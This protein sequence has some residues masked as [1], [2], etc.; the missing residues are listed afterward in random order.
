MR[1]NRERERV[2]GMSAEAARTEVFYLDPRNGWAAAPFDAEGNQIGEAITAFRQ[3]EAVSLI[4]ADRPDL[5]THVFNRDGTLR[6]IHP[7]RG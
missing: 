6:R 1:P 7:P 4:R 2:D 3:R 5:D